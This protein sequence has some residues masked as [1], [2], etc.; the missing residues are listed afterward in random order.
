MVN[1]INGLPMCLKTS[2]RHPDEAV[3]ESVNRPN[4]DLPNRGKTSHQPGDK[5]PLS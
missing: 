4:H 2:C 1:E 3:S 5:M